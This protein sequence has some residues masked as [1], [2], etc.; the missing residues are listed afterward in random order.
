VRKYQDDFGDPKR[1]RVIACEGSF[2][3]RTLAAL[4][5]AGNPKYLKGY[6]PVVE[7]F[8]QVP[9]ENLNELRQ[10]SGPETA[11]I[12]VEQGEAACAPAGPIPAGS[13][14]VRRIWPAALLRRGAMRH[15]PHR[16]ALRS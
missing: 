7:G 9:F 16:Q 13:P 3:G 14:G 10:R 12:L 4:A 6:D 1:F 5:A 2:H 8:E 11:A 15:G